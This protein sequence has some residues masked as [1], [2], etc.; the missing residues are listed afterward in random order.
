M[1]SAIRSL[2]QALVMSLLILL[3]IP[4]ITG[5]VSMAVAFHQPGVIS[6]TKKPTRV[7]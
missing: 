6:A 5:I 3:S 4:A 1:S 2:P 7:G